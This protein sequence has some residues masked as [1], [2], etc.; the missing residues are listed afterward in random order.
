MCV[1]V[2]VCVLCVR[3]CVRACVRV[4]VRRSP[5][6]QVFASVSRSVQNRLLS[7]QDLLESQIIDAKTQHTECL[8]TLVSGFRIPYAPRTGRYPPPSQSSS[9]ISALCGFPIHRWSTPSLPMRK[10]PGS[11]IRTKNFRYIQ[12]LLPLR[13]TAVGKVLST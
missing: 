5:T 9:V 3:A 11:S 1:C 4:C 6:M 12:G 8:T 2:C 10:E 7:K 13:L